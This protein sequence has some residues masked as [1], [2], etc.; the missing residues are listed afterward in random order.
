MAYVTTNPP[1]LIAQGIGGAGKFW[2]YESADTVL[3]VRAANYITNAY[4]LGMRAGDTVLIRDTA[5]PASSWATMVTV[6]VNGAGDMSDGTAI[7]QTN[8]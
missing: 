1:K 3:T 5:T 7:A 6:T 8:T 4:L 2:H